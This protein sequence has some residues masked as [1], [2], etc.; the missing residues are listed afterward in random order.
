M[1]NNLEIS[2]V[3]LCVT[4]VLSEGMICLCK[5]WEGGR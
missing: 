3:Q 1:N 4:G 2:L 5:L